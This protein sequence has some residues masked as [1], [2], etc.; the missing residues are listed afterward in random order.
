MMI[1]VIAIAAL[2]MGCQG[3]MIETEPNCTTDGGTM[4]DGTIGEAQNVWKIWDHDRREW[5]SHFEWLEDGLCG[6]RETFQWDSREDA[7]EA[8]EM[9][10]QEDSTLIP[11]LINYVEFELVRVEPLPTT[12]T[13]NAESS[14][15]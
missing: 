15:P 1:K 6:S 8:I 2:L 7:S 14:E 11:Q 12:A 4:Q 9:A 3:I 10:Y 13:P 5:W